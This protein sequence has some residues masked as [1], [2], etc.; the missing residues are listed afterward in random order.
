MHRI[1]LLFLIIFLIGADRPTIAQ[2]SQTPPDTTLTDSTVTSKKDTASNEVSSQASEK[3]DQAKK[4]FD[5]MGMLIIIT[6]C[7]LIGGYAN[8]RRTVN[9]LTTSAADPPKDPAVSDQEGT[10]QLVKATKE[11][12]DQYLRTCLILGVVAAALVPLFLNSVSSN[13]LTKEDAINNLIFAG[14]C[15]LA[16][17]SSASFI[18]TL[19][20]RILNQAKEVQNQTEKQKKETE[21]LLKSTIEIKDQVDA[22]M[23]LIPQSITQNETDIESEVEREDN[24]KYEI[25]VPPKAKLV[26]IDIDGSRI[27]GSELPSA[28]NG[29]VK[30]S[31][32]VPLVDESIFLIIDAVG[33]PNNEIA[34]TSFKFLDLKVFN[35]PKSFTIG[36]NRRGQLATESINLP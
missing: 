23:A 24:F 16:A 33:E 27:E 34:L 35:E 29:I 25:K 32:F 21:A 5:L 36:D 2:Q 13:L 9:Q 20:Q 12:K 28:E 26:R 1:K 3:T 8:Y 19:A 31:K 22:Q 17:I 15:L 10:A 7:G 30:G 14:F 18:D 4:P 6:L 11:E